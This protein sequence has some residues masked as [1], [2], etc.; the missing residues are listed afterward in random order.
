[1]EHG[2]TKPYIIMTTSE[3]PRRIDFEA[4]SLDRYV[5]DFFQ[6]FRPQASDRLGYEN[7]KFYKVEDL[8]PKCIEYRY[9]AYKFAKTIKDRDES[10]LEIKKT[11]RNMITEGMPAKAA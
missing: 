1:M 6:C 10:T 4:V 2:K 5:W 8:D 11:I 9:V 7:G 3:P